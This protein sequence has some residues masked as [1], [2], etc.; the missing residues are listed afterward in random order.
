MEVYTRYFARLVAANASQIFPGQSRPVP[1][2]GNHHLLVAEMRK[3]S[4]EFP[5]ARKIAESIE[6]GTEDVF[7]NFDLST[8]ME[9]FQ[10]DALQKTLLALAFKLG[11]R[12]DLK[13]RGEWT[14]IGTTCCTRHDQPPRY[15]RPTG[16]YD[17]MLTHVSST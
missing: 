2:P 14:T 13:T 17:Y 15:H 10:L 12:S 6:T 9:H 4:L 11:P 3:I 7:H 8:F 5:Q 1:N 16:C